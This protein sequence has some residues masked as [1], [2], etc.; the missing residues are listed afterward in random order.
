[1]ATQNQEHHDQTPYGKRKTLHSEEN[2]HTQITYRPQDENSPRLNQNSQKMF[3][4]LDH[5]ILSLFWE[6]QNFKIYMCE[7]V[8]GQVKLGFK[9]GCSGCTSLKKKVNTV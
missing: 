4:Q 6:V 1:M 3:K 7:E 5:F 2:K 8:S 9:S